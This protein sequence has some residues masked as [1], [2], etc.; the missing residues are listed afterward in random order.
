MFQFITY[1]RYFR[2]HS[3][4]LFFT[5][6][7]LA[8][9][10]FPWMRANAGLI[11]PSVVE[12]GITKADVYTFEENVFIG[13]DIAGDLTA[14]G[15]TVTTVGMILSDALLAGGEVDVFGDVQDDL[16]V[17][18]GAVIIDS[19][20]GGDLAVVGGDVYL[21]DNA[22]IIGDIL[23]MGG[24]VIFEG[25]AYG[26]MT[27][28]G[29][30]VEIY[31]DIVGNV[32]IRSAG[33]VTIGRHARLSENLTYVA[34]SPVV[35]AQGAMVRGTIVYETTG[36]TEM[37]GVRMALAMI[38][39]LIAA[40]KILYAVVAVSIIVSL[41]GMF[42]REVVMTGILH[43]GRTVLF[44][45]AVTLLI[46]L[47]VFLLAL[48]G[49]GLFGGIA[50]GIL[51]ALF[52]L[53]AKIYAGV[54]VGALLSRFIKG[55]ILITLPWAIAGVIVLELLLIIPVLGVLTQAALFLIASGAL[56]QTI[57]LRMKKRETVA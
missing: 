43:T 57:R 12:G 49:I 34:P 37:V 33:D 39:L 20:I 54:T 53:V 2:N 4:T 18:G 31:G 52:V 44:G 42:S 8:A 55:E 15:A 17:A 48:S 50:L 3:R 40:G 51:Y 9:L 6:V 32:M 30:S 56:V 23:V 10:S 5:L 21:S 13:G 14:A 45:A 27:V 38:L 36:G 47:T 22:V 25:S 46:P 19:T 16:R 29:G 26:D 24:S 41:F 28:Y 11:N 1:S 7:L 35:M